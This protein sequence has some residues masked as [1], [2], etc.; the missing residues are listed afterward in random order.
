[1]KNNATTLDNNSMPTLAGPI[2]S[3]DLV[4]KIRLYEEDHEL[5]SKVQDQ[6][7]TIFR[8]I[9]LQEILREAV[10]AGL[11]IV[12]KRYRAAVDAAKKAEREER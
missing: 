7:Q 2:P 3:S 6:A 9:T 11:P 5:A 10:H 8:Q 4:S 12:A 1:M